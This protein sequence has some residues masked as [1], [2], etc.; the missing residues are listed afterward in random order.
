[1]ALFGWFSEEAFRLLQAVGLIASLGFTAL[2]VH[3]EDRSRRVSNLL[4]LTAAHREIWTQIHQRPELARVL[5]AMADLARVPVTNAEALFVTFLL[6]HLSATYRALRLGMFSTRQALDR[7]IRWF[8]ALPIPRAVW[9]RSKDLLEP[10]FVAFVDRCLEPDNQPSTG[11]GE[12]GH[13]DRSAR[14]EGGDM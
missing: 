3:R 11:S 10:D 4:A 5:E 13:Q 2:V 14:P 7:D 6:L 8:L 12:A 1:M 9:E